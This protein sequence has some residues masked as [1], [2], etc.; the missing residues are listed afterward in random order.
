MF[1][2]EYLE[3]WE[4]DVAVAYNT[5]VELCFIVSRNCDV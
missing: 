5:L 3:A 4:T 2:I 1:S